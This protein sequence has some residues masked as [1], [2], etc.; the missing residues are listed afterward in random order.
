MDAQERKIIDAFVEA[1]LG[2]SRAEAAR[3]V[4]IVNL[5]LEE[6]IY[7]WYRAGTQYRGDALKTEI[8]SRIL[9]AQTF[10]EWALVATSFSLRPYRTWA[11]EQLRKAPRPTEQGLDLLIRSKSRSLRELAKE[12][13]AKLTP[14]Q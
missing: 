11:T 7:A 5:T 13:R 14:V 4:K 10:D 12:L 2:T 8:M 6:W 1:N 3:R 9:D